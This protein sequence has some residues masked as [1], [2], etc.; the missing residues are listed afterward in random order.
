MELSQSRKITTAETAVI[1]R[2]FDSRLTKR[3]EQ[4]RPFVSALQVVAVGDCGCD[5]VEFDGCNWADPPSV[6]AEGQGVMPN[7]HPVGVIVFAD[8]EAIRCLEVYSM[9]GDVPRLPV[10]ESL[11]AYS[12]NIG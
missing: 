1:L 11:S 8:D 5:T 12:D 6:V 3:C 9:D 10:P 7:G 4:L 2:L